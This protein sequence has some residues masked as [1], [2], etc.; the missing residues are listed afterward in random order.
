MACDELEIDSMLA[1]ML[2][3]VVKSKLH[4][5]LRRM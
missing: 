5:L 3:L 1:S 4:G 2:S